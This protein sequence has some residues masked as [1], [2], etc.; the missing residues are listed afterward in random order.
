MKRLSRRFFTLCSRQFSRSAA[1]PVAVLVL[2][3]AGCTHIPPAISVPAIDQ[4]ALIADASPEQVMARAEEQ[5][6]EATEQRLAYYAPLHT[7]QARE[8]LNEAHRLSDEGQGESARYKALAAEQLLLHAQQLKQRVLVELPEVLAQQERLQSLGS[9][10][11]YPSRHQD[12]LKTLDDLIELIGLGQTEQAKK[13]QPKLLESM[14]ALEIDTL[15]HQHLG[16]ARSW[17][18]KARSE[19]ADRYAETTF[20][21]AEQTVSAAEQFIVQHRQDPAGIQAAGLKALDVAQRAFYVGYESKRLVGL[22]RLEAE[23]Q[24][25]N[26]YTMLN[27]AYERATGTMQSPQ[28]LLNAAYELAQEMDAR[29]CPEAIPAIPTKPH[30]TPPQDGADVIARPTAEAEVTAEEEATEKQGSPK[31]AGT[32]EKPGATE[33]ARLTEQT[34]PVRIIEMESFKE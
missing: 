12:L 15:I 34:N 9:A 1:L 27:R 23:R 26:V 28:K 24:A 7:R 16:P 31:M 5:W 3:H 20:N 18:A 13:D 11:V 22:N 2:L 32:T 14:I 21:D 29:T 17:L 10:S 25:L 4:A 19:D 33:R 8:Q 30:D 6:A